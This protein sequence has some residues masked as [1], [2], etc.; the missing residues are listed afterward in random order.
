[1][2]STE[3]LIAELAAD[4][5]PVAPGAAA[6]RIA[7]AMLGG[8]LVALLALDLWFGPPLQAVAQSGAM[9][10][11]VK[12]AYAV[13]IAGIAAD[14]ALLS[15]RPGRR[16]GLRWVWLALPPLVIAAAVAMQLADASAATRETL[17]FGS[18]WAQCLIAIST[19]SIPAFVLLLLAFRR[20]AP[21]GLKASGFLAGLS[22]GAAASIVYALYCPETAAPFLLVWY[23]L[24]MLVPATIGALVGPRLLRW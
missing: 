19:T 9:V 16:I 18:T 6:W 8:G 2:V 11:A 17:V 22:A 15:G 1:M 4:V 24:G 13:A 7:A 5:R 10:F 21:L 3:H 12:F 23:S 14:L 20:L